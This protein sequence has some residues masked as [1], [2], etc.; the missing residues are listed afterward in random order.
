MPRNLFT[1]TNQPPTPGGRPNKAGNPGNGSKGVDH[2]D[3]KIKQIYLPD[4]G[5]RYYPS[6]LECPLSQCAYDGDE[7]EAK[8]GSIIIRKRISHAQ[9]LIELKALGL[10][11]PNRDGKRIKGTH[12]V[13][14][15]G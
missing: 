3:S 15:E 8:D 7:V 4:V 13:L 11:L 2:L 12:E 6:C 14:Y 5:C 9:V 10:P 1:S